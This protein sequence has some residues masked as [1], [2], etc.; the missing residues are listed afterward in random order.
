M[1]LFKKFL[2]TMTPE[3]LKKHS[4][5]TDELEQEEN[6]MVKVIEKADKDID[7]LVDSI[8]DQIKSNPSKKVKVNIVFKRKATK[9]VTT[10]TKKPKLLN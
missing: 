6:K 3:E 1:D 10:S 2:A 8:M 5:T 7:K 4:K 9:N